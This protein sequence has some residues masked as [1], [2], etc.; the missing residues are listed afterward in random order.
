MP[1]NNSDIDRKREERISKLGLKNKKPQDVSI[2]I[3]DDD[4]WMARILA[5]FI[6][7][8]G[9]NPIM[10]F[11][12]FAGIAKAVKEK[13]TLIFLDLLMPEMNGDTTLKVLKKIK[14]IKHIPVI[15]V[16]GHIEEKVLAE[17]FREG[18]SAFLSKPFSKS[19]LANKI[20]EGLGFNIFELMKNNQKADSELL[21]VFD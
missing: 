4:R 21:S 1:K 17:A 8:L 19:S 9:F 20:E 12:P 6:S 11:D 18:A 10:V 5:R 3:I 13:P 16:S 14:S 7:S 2:L 15:I